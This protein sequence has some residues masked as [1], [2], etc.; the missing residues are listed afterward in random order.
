M[1][2]EVWGCSETFPITLLS[3]FVI[4]SLKYLSS[5][6]FQVLVNSLKELLTAAIFDIN[7]SPPPW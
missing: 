7:Q 1:H 5:N 3:I 2:N 4:I 6:L